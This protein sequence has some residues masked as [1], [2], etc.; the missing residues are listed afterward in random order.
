MRVCT[1]CSRP[2]LRAQLFQLLEQPLY[3]S[4]M[5]SLACCCCPPHWPQFSTA[6]TIWFLCQSKWW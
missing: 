6:I 3:I 4:L 5:D 1:V 2:T